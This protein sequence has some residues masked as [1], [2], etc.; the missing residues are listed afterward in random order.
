MKEKAADWQIKKLYREAF[1]LVKKHKVLWILGTAAASVTSSQFGSRGSS[2]TSNFL[3]DTDKHQEVGEKIS[4]VLGAATTSSTEMFKH[5]FSS[6]PLW[7]YI[8]LGIELVLFFIFTIIISYIYRSWISAALLEG[9]RLAMGKDPVTI[10]ATSEKALSKLP[11][12]L[13]LTIVPGLVL[14]VASLITFP[15]LAIILITAPVVIKIPVGILLVGCVGVIIYCLIYLAFSQIWAQRILLSE[16]MP[17]KQALFTGYR[18]AKKK[19]TSM[20]A[21]AIVNTIASALVIAVPV[22]IILAISFGVIMAVLGT[23]YSPNQSQ[24]MTFIPFACVALLLFITGFM[25]VNGLITAFKAS[26]W[27]LAYKAIQG[28][29]EK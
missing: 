3:K 24:I 8:L 27:S 7:V 23:A 22:I 12:F 29:Y 19:G 6:V 15:L 2:N 26:V 16:K 4:Q 20:V 10:R 25:F 21:L 17:A 28:K 11:S 13:W 5:L 18:I 1:A 9:V 14:G